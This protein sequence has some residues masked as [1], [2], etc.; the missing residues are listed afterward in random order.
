[1]TDTLFLDYETRSEADLEEV[2]AFE[3]ATHPSTQI[4]CVAWA[5]NDQP[6]RSWSPAIPSPYGEFIRNLVDPNVTKVAANAN[7]DKLITA[8]VLSRIVHKPEIATVKA[9]EW[10]CTMARSCAVALPRNLAAA[11]AVLELPHQKDKEGHRLMLKYCKPRK[12]TLNNKAKYH[13]KL[14]EL[15]RI[16]QYCE[17]DIRAMRALYHALPPL[18][19]SEREIYLLD[20][21][22]NNRGFFVD[23]P[24]VKKVLTLIDKEIPELNSETYKITKGRVRTAN[25]R[26]A[27]RDWLEENGCYLPDLKAATIVDV[28]AEGLATGDCKRLLEI[29]QMTAKTSTAK[30]QAFDQRSQSDSRVRDILVYHGASTGRWA[31]S[32]I[33]PQNFPR[34]HL[35]DTTRAIELIEQGKLD[36]IRKEFGSPMKVF[37]TC[38]RSMIKATPDTEFFCADYSAIEARVVL[39]LAGD[40][41]GLQFYRDGLDSY[42]IMASL[43][44]DKPF[45]PIDDLERDIG[46]RT[47]LGCGFGM[48]WKKF[49]TTVK[50]QCNRVISDDLAKRAVKIYREAHPWVTKLWSNLEYASI[51]AT[52]RPGKVYTV[53]KTSWWRSGNYLHCKL[54]S[55]RVLSYFGPEIH[56]R[57]TPWGEKKNTLHFYGVDALTKR[58][59]LQHSYGGL[60]CENVTQAVAADVMRFNML[61]VDKSPYEI[62]LTVHDEV[63]TE[64]LKG[65]G[66]LKEFETLMGGQPPWAEGL[67]IKVSGWTGDRYRK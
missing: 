52:Q 41:R 25:Q 17:A 4:L 33:Q 13:A 35:K 1:M 36:L 54:P 39:W 49:Q 3:Y 48:G 56:L 29:R 62:L 10:D 32:G 47:E 6:V 23:R 60:L 67:P 28:L 53:N 55:G 58:W 63:L 11:C 8:H 31:G 46:K 15:K 18:S 19:P 61:R 66:D 16:I 30:Y 12:A 37:A 50:Q 22:I 5:L 34:P 27:L 59:K 9:A 43:I 65:E 26:E 57:E 2:G 51:R 64:R 7:F 14:S 45:D 40:D 21:R 44:F 38:T 42:V 24:L 20:Q